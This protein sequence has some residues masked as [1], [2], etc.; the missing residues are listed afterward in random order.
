MGLTDAE[1]NK[2]KLFSNV[3][4]DRNQT[5]VILGRKLSDDEWGELKV[6][7]I[8]TKDTSIFS[9]TMEKVKQQKLYLIQKLEE[10]LK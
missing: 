4:L 3:K 10:R 2:L 9:K 1:L 7:E 6:P 5:E 8:K